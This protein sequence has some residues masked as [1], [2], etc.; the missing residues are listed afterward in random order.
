MRTEDGIEAIGITPTLFG[1]PGA[2][3]ECGFEQVIDDLLGR[4]RGELFLALFGIGL[5]EGV[6]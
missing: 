6:R 1:R 3:G 5:A 4:G 2:H